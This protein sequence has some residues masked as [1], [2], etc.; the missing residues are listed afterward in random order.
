M[1]KHIYQHRL[2]EFRKNHK[3]KIFHKKKLELGR[4]QF[5]T[6]DVYFNG[7]KVKSNFRP[8][9][10]NQP[11]AESERSRFEA[12]V[13][14][15]TIK[16]DYYSVVT[17]CL[18]SIIVYTYYVKPTLTEIYHLAY[19]TGLSGESTTTLLRFLGPILGLDEDDGLLLTVFT[20]CTSH[21]TLLPF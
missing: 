10:I 6:D 18:L 20:E 13:D 12:Q 21:F 17:L 11:G 3:S 1:K 14:K 7:I 4:I 9:L 15:F 8:V 16:R 2:N 5:V 19:G